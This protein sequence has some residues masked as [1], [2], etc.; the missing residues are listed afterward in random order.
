MESYYRAT[1]NLWKC[2]TWLETLWAFKK[3]CAMVNPLLLQLHVHALDWLHGTLQPKSL[4]PVFVLR[5]GAA[6][7]A[8]MA[9]ERERASV[10]TNIEELLQRMTAARLPGSDTA[11]SQTCVSSPFCCHFHGESSLP[12]FVLS[13][14][15]C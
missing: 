14:Y 2:S 3:H 7:A 9:A 4:Q 6:S 11:T 8:E 1:S 5:V 12:V 15:V 13:L 10:H